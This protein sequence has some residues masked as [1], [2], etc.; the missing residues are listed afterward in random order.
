MLLFRMEFSLLGKYVLRVGT[1]VTRCPCTVP[2]V[3]FSR[4]RF[5]DCTRF[6]AK[7]DHPPGRPHHTAGLSEQATVRQSPEGFLQVTLPLT[8]SSIEPFESLY[9]VMFSSSY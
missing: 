2:D 8:V 3:R 6:R 4:T 5:L 7:K 1:P 9:Y